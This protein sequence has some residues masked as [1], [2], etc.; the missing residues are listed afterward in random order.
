VVG[1]KKMNAI[2]ENI[3]GPVS[4]AV[5]GFARD[6]AGLQKEGEV[7]I[8]GDL[9]QAD[10]DAYARQ[11]LNFCCKMRC[12]VTNLLRGR[13]VSRRGTADDRGD[14][15]MAEFEAVVAGDGGGLVGEAEVVEDGVH[16]VAG[17][18]AGEDAAGAVGPVGAGSKAED[19]DPCSWVAETGDRTSPV[20]LVL[21]GTTL[22]FADSAAVVAEAGTTFA[23]NDGVVN[24]LQKGRRSLYV[25]AGHC[26]P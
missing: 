1:G 14:P 5:C 20:G 4:K 17:A 22:G 25:G 10:D 18:V 26:I 3:F 8:E 19:K 11:G 9:A 2:R 16:E 15:G 12:A 24:L 7:A 6:N 13:F 23:R 21:I